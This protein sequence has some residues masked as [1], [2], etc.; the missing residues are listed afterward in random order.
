[1]TVY[2]FRDLVEVEHVPSVSGTSDVVSE[3]DFFWI[4]LS[5]IGL[6]FVFHAVYVVCDEHLVPGECIS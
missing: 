1:M 6:A 4:V 2:T 5:I 3:L